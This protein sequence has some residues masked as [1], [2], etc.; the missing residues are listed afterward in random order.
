MSPLALTLFAGRAGDRN[1]RAIPGAKKVAEALSAATGLPL[2]TVGTPQP[3]LAAGWEIELEAARPGLLELQRRLAAHFAAGARPLTAMGRCASGL[4][5]LPAVAAA[6]P[7]AAIVWFDA[8][9]DCNAPRFTTS[10]YLGGM[11]LTGAAGRWETG[12]GAGL[13]LAQ[14][15]LV[16][17][18]DL[19]PC[20]KDLIESG[21]IQLVEAGPGLAERLRGAVAGRKAYVHLDCDVL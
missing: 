19:D 20:E 11:I 6:H 14:M 2:G 16:G 17:A 18:R 12:L 13:D 15:V 4:G 10:G 5:T 7:E 21:T 1:D 8:H 9:G 3:P